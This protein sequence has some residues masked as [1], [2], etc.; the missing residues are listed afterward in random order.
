MTTA[1]NL[2]A[3]D[4]VDDARRWAKA[5]GIVLLLHMVA[6][7][8]AASWKGSI[9]PVPPEPPAI[10]V[11][12]A[13]M[14]AAMQAASAAPAASA[15]P[16]PQVTP[17]KPRPVEQKIVEP[18]QQPRPLAQVTPEVAL[19]SPAESAATAT[20][21]TG[22]TRSSEAGHG[23]TGGRGVAGRS[24]GAQAQGVETT[25]SGG[26]NDAAALWRGRLL[27][28]LDRHKRYP[29]A[30][31]MMKR[32]GR[33][34]MNITLDR[35]GHVVSAAVDRSAGFK[36]FDVEAL[37]TVQRANPLPPPPPEVAGASIPVVVPIGFYLPK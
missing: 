18:V 25:S 21:E 12:L 4:E 16:E 13:P 6:V 3:F 9:D 36:A 22:N 31:R 27:A 20:P 15:T 1:G 32:E 7:L 8:L 28:H 10:S 33:V 14:P 11:E 5:A 29:P 35:R 24:G 30:A 34:H 26:S 19:P 37:E 23:E 2:P 17:A